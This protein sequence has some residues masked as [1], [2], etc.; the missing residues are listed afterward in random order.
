MNKHSY[1]STR[2]D[3]LNDIKMYTIDKQYKTRRHM[4]LN[5]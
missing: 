4:G 2:L 1:L 5:A 3:D